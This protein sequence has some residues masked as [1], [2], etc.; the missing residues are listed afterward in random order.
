MLRSARMTKLGFKFPHDEWNAVYNKTIFKEISKYSGP[1]NVIPAG[2]SAIYDRVGPSLI[3]KRQELALK[4]ILGIVSIEDGFREYES[5]FKSI[6]GVQIL[7][8]LNTRHI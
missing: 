3:K 1:K 8:E 6:N 7:K 4:M 5:Y 2:A